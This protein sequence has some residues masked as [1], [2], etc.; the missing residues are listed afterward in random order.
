MSVHRFARRVRTFGVGLALTGMLASLSGPTLAQQNRTVCRVQF[1]GHSTVRYNP[2]L[3]LTGRII[4]GQHNYD[5]AV[6]QGGSTQTRFEVLDS[7][8]FLTLYILVNE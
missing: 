5:S 4:I 8:G 7:D 2:A 1:T 6:R 3:N